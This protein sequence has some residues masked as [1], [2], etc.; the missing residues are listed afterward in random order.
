MRDPK[1]T[2]KF[3]S[4][5][6]GCNAY[7]TIRS[8][9]GTGI[10]AFPEKAV[11]LTKAVRHREEIEF[12]LWAKQ[13]MVKDQSSWNA[14]FILDVKVN[15]ANTQERELGTVSDGD[16]GVPRSK[17]YEPFAVIEKRKRRSGIN[18]NPVG[19]RIGIHTHRCCGW[20]LGLR[21]RDAEGVT[22]NI[23]MIMYDM[24]L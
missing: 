17:F 24:D 4:W 11:T 7:R 15:S 9:D 16:M 22:S 13:T 6:N 14:S 3:R 19:V 23:F 21:G 10:V 1:E 18:D 20:P 2:V 12:Q 5:V 8:N